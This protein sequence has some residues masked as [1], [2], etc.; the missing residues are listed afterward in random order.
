MLRVRE[1]EYVSSFTNV[2]ETRRINRQQWD[3]C[4]SGLEYDVHGK[5]ERAFAALKDLNKIEKDKV[6]TNPI[7]IHKWETFYKDL[8]T[9]KDDESFCL[10]QNDINID[11]LNIDDF[12][13]ASGVPPKRN[14]LSNYPSPTTST[15][16][17]VNGT[18]SKRWLS[19]RSNDATPNNGTLPTSMS[20]IYFSLSA[21]VMLFYSSREYCDVI[22][23][24]HDSEIFSFKLLEIINVKPAC[25]YLI[26]ASFISY[27]PGRAVKTN[28]RRQQLPIILHK[29]PDTFIFVVVRL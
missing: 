28:N 12:G 19:S 21:K 15:T 20:V 11:P 25:Y 14:E 16:R 10:A 26:N 22:C 9:T 4:I 23:S 5:Q 29:L 13:K 8:W 6:M 2:K 18:S 27:Y 1:K 17:V 3:R 7:T 24:P